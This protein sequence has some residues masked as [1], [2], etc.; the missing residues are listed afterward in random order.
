MADDGSKFL[1]EDARFAANVKRL[2]ERAGWSQGELARRMV[3][4]GR[5]GFHQTTI[6]R[7]EKNERPVRISEAIGLAEV[8]DTTVTNMVAPPAEWQILG[9]LGKEI[10]WTSSASAE[11]GDAAIRF[12]EAQRLLK[13][14]LKEADELEAEGLESEKIQLLLRGYRENAEG[15]V[16]LTID[17]AIDKAIFRESGDFDEE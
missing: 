11:L 13:A 6:S 14:V 5:D 7:I 10:R 12:L 4:A 3:A 2:R 8:F 15:L 9:K 17:Q 16:A 1:N